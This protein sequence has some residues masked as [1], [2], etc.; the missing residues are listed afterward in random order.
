MRLDHLLSKEHLPT[1]VG[2]EPALPA[3]GGGVLDGGD[4]G[5]FFFGNGRGNLVQLPFGVVGTD[6]SGA[7]EGGCRA[8]CWVLK[9]QPV[10]VSFGAVGERELVG[11]PGMTWPRIP[12]TVVVLVWGGSGCGLVVC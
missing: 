11:L 8:P 4:T 10:V 6:C 5:E 3:C 2:K 7:A 1:K 12:I 9:E